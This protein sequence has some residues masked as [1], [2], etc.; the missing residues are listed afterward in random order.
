MTTTPAALYLLELLEVSSHPLSQF[1]KF[2]GQLA[3]AERQNLLDSGMRQGML[4]GMAA[5]HPGGAQNQDRLALAHDSPTSSRLLAARAF[6]AFKSR[7]W[8]LGV[9]M[10]QPPLRHSLSWYKTL[11]WLK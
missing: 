5:N 2:L 10:G 9:S 4:Q 3:T 7:A 11:C 8:G 6:A 1:G